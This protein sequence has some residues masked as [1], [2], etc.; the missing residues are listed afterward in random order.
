[1][2]LTKLSVVLTTVTVLLA[3]CSM[4]PSIQKAA[5]SKSEF[6]DAVYKGETVDIGQDNSGAERY[7]VFAQ[8]AT[9]FV[10]QS[11]TRSNAEERANKFCEQKDKKAKILQERKSSG[12]HVLGNF[13]RSEL[14]FV[15]VN[16]PAE[17]S[18]GDVRYNKL[19]NLKKLLDDGVLTKSEFES[20]KAKI[21]GEK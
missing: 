18:V 15:C 10:P 3:G 4:T 5:D 6:E 16:T 12:A 9:G 2:K 8:G 19:S 11:A 13:P 20:E 17:G 1:M 14:I 7:R 21:L